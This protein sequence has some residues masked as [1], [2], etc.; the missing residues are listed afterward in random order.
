MAHSY[1]LE[2]RGPVQVLFH[3][4]R[5]GYFRGGHKGT[6]IVSPKFRPWSVSNRD[7]SPCEFCL[8]CGFGINCMGR[9][10][11][12]P[13]DAPVVVTENSASLY[14]NNM[15]QGSPFPKTTWLIIAFSLT[16]PHLSIEKFTGQSNRTVTPIDWFLPGGDRRVT[17]SGILQSGP[18][19]GEAPG[20]GANS[21]MQ[22]GA[23]V[24]SINEAE[25]QDNKYRHG[26]SS[27]GRRTAQGDD[28][29]FASQ[30]F[31]VF[32]SPVWRE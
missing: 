28:E 15:M 2:H 24:I 25:E 6:R 19:G 1:T 17:R 31:F 14:V 29:K 13:V 11:S 10:Q 12:D 4:L 32:V 23:G 26:A 16:L 8:C 20:T 5:N 7:K 27:G 22:G 18:V 9:T 3:W 30:L 21:I